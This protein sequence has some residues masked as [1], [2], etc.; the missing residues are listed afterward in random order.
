MLQTIKKD[1]HKCPLV[2]YIVVEVSRHF[3]KD[4]V[5]IVVNR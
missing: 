3:F 2:S 1:S 5:E 4:C